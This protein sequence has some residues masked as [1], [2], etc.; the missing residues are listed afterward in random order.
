MAL[1]CFPSATVAVEGLVF[2]F[3]AASVADQCPSTG[4]IVHDPVQGRAFY[5][6][7]FAGF[8]ACPSGF[9]HWQ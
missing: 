7:V 2:D 4:C 5:F 3:D 1:V 9:G 8:D 6:A